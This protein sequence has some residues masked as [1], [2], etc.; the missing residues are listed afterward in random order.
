MP[1][2]GCAV[3]HATPRVRHPDLTQGVRFR[4]PHP[5][6]GTQGSA[7]QGAGFGTQGA[8]MRTQGAAFGLPP[9]SFALPHPGSGFGLLFSVGAESE[10]GF[11]YAVGDEAGQGA[12][13]VLL[14]V[15]AV[16][17]FVGF[18]FEERLLAGGG[19]LWA[20]GR[21]VSVSFQAE[22]HDRDAFGFA[23]LEHGLAVVSA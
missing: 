17:A 18:D 12:G 3:S 20:D 6:F 8:A 7:T 16:D 15:S 14:E 23:Q 2:P 10:F 4:M 1:H 19:G 5:G 9:G 13:A 22:V 21:E 11:V